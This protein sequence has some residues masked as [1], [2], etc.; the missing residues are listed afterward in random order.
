MSSI[1]F[2]VIASNS[3]AFP[4]GSRVGGYV[5]NGGLVELAGLEVERITSATIR[6]AVLIHTALGYQFTVSREEYQRV[7]PNAEISLD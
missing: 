1:A 6:T 4:A 3:V 5:N 2:L 7:D